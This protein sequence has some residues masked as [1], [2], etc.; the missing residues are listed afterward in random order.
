MIVVD[1]QLADPRIIRSISN[2][3]KGRVISVIEMRPHTTVP[4]DAIPELLRHLKAPT[5]DD[6]LPPF[7][8]K[9]SGQ[10]CL[11]RDLRQASGGAFVGGSAV[12]AGRLQQTQLAHKAWPDGHCHIVKRS[13][14]LVLLCDRTEHSAD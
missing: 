10:F 8:A 6:Q 7:L 12:G 2:W 4:D 3:Y 9:G 1:E 11:L 5:F 13:P 14:S